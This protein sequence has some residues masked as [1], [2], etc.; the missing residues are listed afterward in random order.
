MKDAYSFPEIVSRFNLPP[1]EGFFAET[2]HT[3][4]N[5]RNLLLY[6]DRSLNYSHLDIYTIGIKTAK[7]DEI[8]HIAKFHEEGIGLILYRHKGLLL[9]W[10]H[11]VKD[12]DI[13][14]YNKVY[15]NTDMA[16]VPFYRFL[17]NNKAF[18]GGTFHFT[19]TEQMCL[20]AKAACSISANIE[21]IHGFFN[22]KVFADYTAYKEKREVID[23]KRDNNN[24]AQVHRIGDHLEGQ[25]ENLLQEGG[26]SPH[27]VQ[28]F[29]VHI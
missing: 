20:E 17:V 10:G 25:E 27:E 19:N 2:G 28:D 4:R 22:E 24:S 12:G 16:S 14:V 5:T 15:F 8:F 6:M 21:K 26:Q 18:F 7:W 11:I 29:Q 3:V 23:E 9:L 1:R 13:T